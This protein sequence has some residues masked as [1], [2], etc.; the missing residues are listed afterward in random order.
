MLF[1]EIRSTTTNP[2]HELIPVFGPLSDEIASR[3]SAYQRLGYK[4]QGQVWY[5]YDQHQWTGEITFTH[6]RETVVMEV[7]KL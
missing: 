3:K 2:K 1:L 7:T 5:D 6:P 4:N